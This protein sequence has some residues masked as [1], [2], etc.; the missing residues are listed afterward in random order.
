MWTRVELKANAKMILKRTYWMCFLATLILGFLD[1]SGA[2]TSAVNITRQ[3][4]PN[5]QQE[6][7]HHLYS[8]PYEFLL[9][10]SGILLAIGVIAVVVTLFVSYPVMVGGKRFFMASREEDPNLGDLFFCFGSGAYLHTIKTVFLMNLYTALW[11]MLF[12]IPGII[13]HYEYFFVPYL[14]SENPKMDTRRAFELSR[15]M[16]YGRKWDMFVLD[17]SF[18]GWY[19]LGSLCFGIGVLFV[20]PYYQAVTAELYAASRAYVLQTHKS[21]LWELPGFVK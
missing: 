19:F 12:F 11:S 9:A 4:S 13:K 10:V 21:D 6:L 16:S 5:Q 3:V 20:V 7:E 18:I 17:L 15:E 2:G 1:G 8:R 14:L